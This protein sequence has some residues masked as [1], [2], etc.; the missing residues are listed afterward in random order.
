MESART[1]LSKHK[2]EKMMVVNISRYVVQQA[3][4]TTSNVY[5]Q[6]PVRGKKNFRSRTK[7]CGRHPPFAFHVSIDLHFLKRRWL[8]S[9]LEMEAGAA[10]KISY[11]DNMPI[12]PGKTLLDILDSSVPCEMGGHPVIVYIKATHQL[13]RN[14]VL[15]FVIW[16]VLGSH[17]RPSK[18]RSS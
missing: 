9:V 17:C 14:S 4:L 6:P 13:E 5:S 18:Y 2:K 8:P 15:E 11:H 16:F 7:F 12:E 1:T 3:T 10:T